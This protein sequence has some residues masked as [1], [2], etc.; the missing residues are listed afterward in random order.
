MTAPKKRA[1]VEALEALIPYAEGVEEQPGHLRIEPR[2]I[3]QEIDT[4]RA[5]VEAYRKE[6]GE[7]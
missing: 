3:H 4:A 6:K 2:A 1:L 5:L 7:G